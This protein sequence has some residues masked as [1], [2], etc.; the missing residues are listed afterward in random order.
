MNRYDRLTR[1]HRIPVRI[2]RYF[3]DM[4]PVE[5][6]AEPNASAE[7]EIPPTVEVPS[8]RAEVDWREQSL[9][10]QAEMVNF[11][12]RQDRRVEEAVGNE[13]DRLL[14]Q[15]LPVLDNFDRLMAYKEDTADQALWQGVEL[16]RRE[17]A[18][19]LEAEGISRME[20]LG[21]T[22]NPNEH[23]AVAAVQSTE[24]PGT[25]LE[26]LKPGYYLGDRLLRPAQ[27]VV[28]AD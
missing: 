28:S 1:G 5:V 13:K 24:E 8:P 2:G 22:F 12:K 18:R 25:V 16:T 17:M 23:E 27:V 9:R 11:R 15:L 7:V 4:T 6:A 19:F 21:K 3:P 14:N 20:A 26:E 10:L